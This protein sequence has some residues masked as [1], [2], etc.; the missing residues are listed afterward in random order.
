MV[1]STVSSLYHGIGLW[2]AL[3]L[4][5]ATIL[6]AVAWRRRE[7]RGILAF[8]LAALV[9]LAAVAAIFAF[10]W[11]SYVP[12]RTG[13]QRFVQEASLLAAPYVAVALACLPFSVQRFPWRVLLIGTAVLLLC[14]AGFAQSSRLENILA[15]QHPTRSAEE[16]LAGLKIPPDA[17]VLSNAYTEGY[18]GQVTGAQGLIEG[19]AP[20]TFPRVLRRA[21]K[22]L[23][24]ARAFYNAPA[25]H[26][27]FL[28]K[29]HISY[30][31][32][33]KDGSYSLA[34]NNIFASRV[35]LS[36]LDA[37]PRLRVVRSLDGLKVYRVRGRP[38][39]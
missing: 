27:G 33:S 6:L 34:S 20:Y 11:S 13:A 30:V 37:C 32:V 24:E 9:G 39:G 22:L 18:I 4:S 31:L 17:V 29:E 7:A 35:K 5:A 19:R 1:T 2:A 14:A 21:N 23:R 16:G 12:R 15:V 28:D 36:A 25:A 38:N 8:V 3:V 26:L 10:G